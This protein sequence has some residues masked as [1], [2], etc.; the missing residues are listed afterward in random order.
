MEPIEKHEEGIV[1]GPRKLPV[2]ESGHLNG[3]IHYKRTAKLRTLHPPLHSKAYRRK[4]PI[5]RAFDIF[6]CFAIFVVLA[7]PTIIAV[8]FKLI[9]DGMPLFYN[10]R[11]IGK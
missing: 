1:P 4:I 9:K 7:I 3:A 6:L 10:S 2:N 5:V 11:R 8:I